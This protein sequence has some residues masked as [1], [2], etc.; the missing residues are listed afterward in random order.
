MHKFAYEQAGSVAEATRL[1][2]EEPDSLVL[3]GGT[4]AVV[5]LTLGL[6]RP[7][8]VVDIGAIEGLH[9]MEQTGNAYRLGA[10]TSVRMLEASADVKRRCPLLAE[11]ASQ[12]GSVRVRNAAT[13]GGAIAYG[14]PQTD[15][16]VALVAL[17]ASVEI[18][19]GEGQRTMALDEFFHAPYETDLAPGEIVAGVSIPS[20]DDRTGGCHVKFT[21]GSIEHKPVANVSAIVRLSDAGVCEDARIVAGAVGPTPL[22]AERAAALLRGTQLTGGDIAEAA[23]IAS[24]EADPIDDLRGS[25]WYKRR[26]VR[27]LVERGLKCAILRSKTTG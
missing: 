15:V 8:L 16:P 7:R 18:V 2:T 23:R 10:L 19:S 25:V 21:I 26:I 14:E 3:A 1:L 11:A 9:A 20:A 12:V 4:A 5:M 6:V 13:V 27:A 22:V 17:G 24:E